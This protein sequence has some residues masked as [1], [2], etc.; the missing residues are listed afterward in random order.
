M[1]IYLI[2]RPDSVDYD[3]YDSAVVYAFSEEEAR[4][5][6]PSGNLNS[7]ELDIYDGWIPSEEV[8]VTLLGV[9]SE[10]ITL[11]SSVICASF[12]EG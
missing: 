10:P 2:E 11:K 9:A 1:N 12:N 5:I 3:E 4:K 8:K 7:I 6:H